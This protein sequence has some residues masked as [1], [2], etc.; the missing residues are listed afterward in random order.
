[1][2]LVLLLVLLVLGL[3]LLPLLVLGVSL[4]TCLV[5][6]S[7]HFPLMVVVVVELGEV[8]LVV[9]EVCATASPR[10]PVSI[11][12]AINPIPAIRIRHP[13][14][15]GLGWRVLAITGRKRHPRKPVPRLPRVKKVNPALRAGLSFRVMLPGISASFVEDAHVRSSIAT[16]R[17]SSPG[18]P[19]FSKWSRFGCTSRNSSPR[20]SSSAS[21]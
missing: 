15:V 2:E 19:F 16:S 21:Q 4:R 17:G 10:L 1:V 7:Q 20:L 12:A 18:H 11:A 3:V 5:T 13:S 6:A 8:V 14:L 9:V